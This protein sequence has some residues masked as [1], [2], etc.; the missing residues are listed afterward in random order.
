MKRFLNTIS[1][2]TIFLLS[3]SFLNGQE[4]EVRDTLNLEPGYA[5]DIYYSLKNGE[6][7]NVARNTWDIAFFTPRFSAGI[8]INEG[9]GVQ[10]FSYPNGDTSAWSSIDTSGMSGWTAMNNSPETWEEGAFNRNALGHP[11]YGWGVY[12]QIDHSVYGDS[13]FI[14]KTASATM[15]LRIVKKVSID[16]L[17]YFTYA[18]VDGSN[19][20]TVELDVVPFED[21]NFIYYS[22]DNN[23]V[24]DREPSSESWDILFTKY[25]DMVETNEGGFA[26]YLVTGAT[27]NVNAYSS[28]VYPADPSYVDWTAQ[29]FD[30]AKNAIGYDWKSFD[31]GTFQWVVKDSNYY[32]VKTVDGDVYKLQFKLWEGSSTGLFVLDRWLVSLSSVDEFG[33]ADNGFDIYPNPSSGSVTI[34]APSALNGEFDLRIMDQAGRLVYLGRYSGKQLNN[35]IKLSNLNMPGGIYLVSVTGNNYAFTQKLMVR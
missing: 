27:N 2:I 6:V 13:V 16:N 3:S 29:P 21:K 11:D 9:N 10:L 15:K 4:A 1:V 5:N 26:P 22:L 19:E 31:M 20:Q 30:S 14:I 28:N 18:N 24:V 17:Y 23:E 35:G 7:S 34:A 12:N 8:I 32:F 25:I 33:L